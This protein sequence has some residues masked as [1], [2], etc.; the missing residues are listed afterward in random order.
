MSSHGRRKGIFIAIRNV[1]LWMWPIWAG[2]VV[3][4][5][6]L[7]SLLFFTSGEETRAVIVNDTA[8][9]LHVF[10]CTNGPCVH[11][12]GTT[13]EVLAPGQATTQFWA[14]PDDGGPIGVASIPHEHLIGC[15]SDPHAGQNVSHVYSILL[16][17]ARPCPGQVPDRTRSVT[18]DGS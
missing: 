16:S 12:D 13:D 6:G 2:G 14:D 10:Y 15:L 4:L 1:P 5:I 7:V 18:M 9:P 11:G 17:T 8:A 3:V